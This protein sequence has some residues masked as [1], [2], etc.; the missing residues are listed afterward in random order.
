MKEKTYLVFP[1]WFKFF[2]NLSLED[3]NALLDRWIQEAIEENGLQFGGGGLKDEWSGGVEKPSGED[4][5]EA[6]RV[7][8]Q[9]WLESNP[10]ILEYK[11]GPLFSEK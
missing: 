11:V 3:R 4:A 7:A 10:L 6:D 8:V 5:T 2:P 1:I 9:R